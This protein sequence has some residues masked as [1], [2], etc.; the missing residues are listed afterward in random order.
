MTRARQTRGKISETGD[1]LQ[2]RYD[3]MENKVMSKYEHLSDKVIDMEQRFENKISE[4]PLQSVGIAFGVGLVAG[5]VLL[6]LL[7]R[8]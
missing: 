8:R 3:A 7:K 4:N 1:K 2:D 5:A 6:G